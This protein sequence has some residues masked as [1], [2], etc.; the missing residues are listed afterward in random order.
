MVRE[1]GWYLVYQDCSD[2]LNAETHEELSSSNEQDSLEEAK[3][4]WGQK[5]KRIE[6][7]SNLYSKTIAVEFPH[8]PQ[9]VHFSDLVIDKDDKRGEATAVEFRGEPFFEEDE[10]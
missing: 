1:T 8:S 10:E 6:E 7:G 9:L 4:R 3:K 5:E 2:P